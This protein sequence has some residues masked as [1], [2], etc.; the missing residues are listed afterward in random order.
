MTNVKMEVAMIEEGNPITQDIKNG[1]LRDYHGQ[2]V[3]SVVTG[4]SMVGNGT[5]IEPQSRETKRVS[6]TKRRSV[7]E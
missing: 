1:K 2:R 3:L 5:S 6:Q 4:L 7:A